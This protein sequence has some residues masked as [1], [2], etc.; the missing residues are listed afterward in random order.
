VVGEHFGRRD[1][2]TTVVLKYQVPT[3]PQLK[4]GGAQIIEE[5]AGNSGH[6]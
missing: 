1:P 6:R 4:P 2:P 3:S 5:P